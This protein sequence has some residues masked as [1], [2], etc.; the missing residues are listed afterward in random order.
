M[1][2]LLVF[3]IK[4][5][6]KSAQFTHCNGK[7]TDQLSQNMLNVYDNNTDLNLLIYASILFVHR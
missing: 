7:N 2:D 5:T 1:G 3:P 6:K 4:L